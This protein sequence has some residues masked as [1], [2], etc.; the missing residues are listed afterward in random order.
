[1][2]AFECQNRFWRLKEPAGS[3]PQGRLASPMSNRAARARKRARR[4]V[5]LLIDGKRKMT[6]IN[7]QPGVAG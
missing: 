1:M 2:L 7:G 3:K 4:I 6:R 5:S